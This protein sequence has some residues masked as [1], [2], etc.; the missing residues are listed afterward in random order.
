VV[1]AA[2]HRPPTDSSVQPQ[3]NGTHE[4]MHREPKRETTRPASRSLR[5]RQGRFNAFRVRYNRVSW[6]PTTLCA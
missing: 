3:D 5:A 4:R 1:D 2:R 6:C